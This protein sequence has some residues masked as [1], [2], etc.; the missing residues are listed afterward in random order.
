MKESAKKE[1]WY[2]NA[3]VEN[4]QFIIKVWILLK[5]KRES[6]SKHALKMKK[7][8]QQLGKRQAKLSHSGGK[9]EK[10]LIKKI[11]KNGERTNTEQTKPMLQCLKN[12]QESLIKLVGLHTEKQPRLL[13]AQSTNFKTLSSKIN[14]KSESR[15]NSRKMRSWI[16]ISI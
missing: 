11:L 5:V 2:L 15:T 6:I 3:T 1:D 16:C 12:V 8:I 7:I 14:K 10:K 4:Q 9:R 13:E